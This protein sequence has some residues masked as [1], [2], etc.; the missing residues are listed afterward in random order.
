MPTTIRLGIVGATGYVG[1]ELCRLLVRHPVF[2]LTA[3]CSQS[4]AGRHFSEIFPAFRGRLDTVLTA[5]DP[6]QLAEACDAVITA[7]PHGVSAQMVPKLLALGLTVLDHSGDFRF[8]SVRTYEQAYRLSHPAPAL[9]EHAVYGLPELHRAAIRTARLI[10]NPGCYPTCAVLAA[11]PLIENGLAD[12]R[13]PVIVDAVSGT[14]GAGR[15]TDAAYGVAEMGQNFKPYGVTGHRHTPEMAEQLNA[16]RPDPAAGSVALTFTPHLLPIGRGMLATLYVRPTA[17]GRAMARSGELGACYLSRYRREPFVRILPAGSL[18]D[19]ASVAG[20]NTCDIAWAY[21]AD[22]DRL[23][24]FA[25]I[26][27]LGKGACSQAIQA[28]NIRFGLA[29]TAGLD[30]L[31]H[32]I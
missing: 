12:L 13:E 16:L 23:K 20:S 25:A 15:R 17:E 24:V 19:V 31:A 9:S 2:R 11:A 32:V 30:H 28:L 22:C 26:D 3:L 29:E 18:P 7:L 27:N 21:D 1:M 14:S 4:Y 5:P 6:G 8:R 10:A